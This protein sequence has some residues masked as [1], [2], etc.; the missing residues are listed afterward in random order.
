MKGPGGEGRPERDR[1]QTA[2]K[3][4]TQA[5]PTPRRTEVR[6]RGRSTFR[7]QRSHLERA[8]VW[9]HEEVAGRKGPPEP[10]R[11]SSLSGFSSST[12]LLGEPP[13]P[14]TRSRPSLSP[15]PAPAP[16][17][18]SR[19]QRSEQS[20]DR[21]ARPVALVPP[22]CVCFLGAAAVQAGSGERPQPDRLGWKPTRPV[23]HVP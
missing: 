19:L 21:R 22:T 6:P 11:P 1:F 23:L 7:K 18:P 16:R 3:R 14:L 5:V 12:P 20:P 13:Q 10:E 9:E 15:G 8:C 4:G 2:S 17:C